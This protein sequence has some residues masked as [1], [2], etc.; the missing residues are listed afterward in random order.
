MFKA[1]KEFLFGKIKD[2]DEKE[3][4]YS[5]VITPLILPIVNEATEDKKPEIVEKKKRSTKKQGTK[6]KTVK[7][8]ENKKP[9]GR[10]PKTAT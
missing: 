3:L 4:D 5:P 6:K 7:T 8:V 9:R 2:K 1:I 10:K